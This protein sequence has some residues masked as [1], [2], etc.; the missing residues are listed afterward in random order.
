MSM[1]VF[2]VLYVDREDKLVSPWRTEDA[3]LVCVLAMEV[4]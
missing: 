2:I 3:S 1:F 4:E